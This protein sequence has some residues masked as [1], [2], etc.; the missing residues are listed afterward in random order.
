MNHTSVGFIHRRGTA[1]PQGMY[2]FARVNPAPTFS[3]WLGLV[4]WF[5]SSPSDF[6]GQPKWRTISLAYQEFCCPATSR[7]VH[8]A[9]SLASVLLENLL[10]WIGQLASIFSQSLVP[11]YLYAALQ[12]SPR[13]SGCLPLPARLGASQ[14]QEPELDHPYNASSQYRTWHPAGAPSVLIK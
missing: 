10:C 14:R 8:L 11:S 4:I 9:S 3:K 2:M 13:P 7:V 12:L 6:N 5:E 1:G